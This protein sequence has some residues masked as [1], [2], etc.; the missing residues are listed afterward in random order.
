MMD[1]GVSSILSMNA[2]R[3]CYITC[4][5]ACIARTAWAMMMVGSTSAEMDWFEDGGVVVDESEIVLLS[6]TQTDELCTVF[7]GCIL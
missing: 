3:C 1:C 7:D 6:Y 5:W 4:I 2:T